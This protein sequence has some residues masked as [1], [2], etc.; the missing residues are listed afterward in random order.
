MVVWLVRLAE[1]QSSGTGIISKRKTLEKYFA[2]KMKSTAAG[3][4]TTEPDTTKFYIPIM[5]DYAKKTTTHLYK[6]D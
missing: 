4:D 6:I 3:S 5:A 1:T 2:T